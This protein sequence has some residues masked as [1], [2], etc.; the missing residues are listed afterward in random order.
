MWEIRLQ[1]LLLLYFLLRMLLNTGGRGSTCLYGLYFSFS[2]SM[3]GMRLPVRG[4]EPPAARGRASAIAV[5]AAPTAEAAAMTSV[6]VMGAT[7]VAVV[8]EGTGSVRFHRCLKRRAHG[9]FIFRSHNQC[10]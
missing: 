10:W 7:R 2:A 3:S 9:V 8:R 6:G 5:Q 1:H 4:V